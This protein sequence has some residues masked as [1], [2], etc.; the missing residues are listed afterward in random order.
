MLEPRHV[1]GLRQWTIDV[2]TY[3]VFT[4]VTFFKQNYHNGLYIVPYNLTLY[5]S[6]EKPDQSINS[7]SCFLAHF[8][9]LA[10]VRVI[11]NGA[12]CIIASVLLCTPVYNTTKTQCRLKRPNWGGVEWASKFKK[13]SKTN[14]MG[15]NG[16]LD[17]VWELYGISGMSIQHLNK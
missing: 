5:F 6:S 9:C 10:F 8:C 4:K 16:G 12:P 3:C 13:K 14:A 2:H 11:I 17:E 1:I 7:I 15:K